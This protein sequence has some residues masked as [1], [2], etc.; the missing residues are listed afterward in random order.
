MQ[1]RIATG[2]RLGTSTKQAN[3]EAVATSVGF[4]TQVTGGVDRA[5]TRQGLAGMNTAAEKRIERKIQDKY[6]FINYFK[7]K[8]TDI[9]KEITSMRGEIE[10][11]NN[12]ITIYNNLNKT[13]ETLS[14]DVQNLEGELADYNLAGD[15]YRSSMRAEDI[16]G[17]FKHIRDN[18]KKKRDD[19]DYL[20]LEKAKREEE[21]AKIEFEHNKIMQAMEQRLNDLE[22]EQKIEYEQ[23]REENVHLVGKIHEVREEINRYNLEIAEGEN[24]LKNN[25]NKREAHKT[26]D[27]TNQYM[28]QI[29]KLERQTNESGKTVEELKA[30]LMAQA[31]EDLQEKSNL[32]KKVLEVKKI[33]DSYKKSISEIEKEMKSTSTNENV[34]AHDSI[35]QKDKEYSQLIDNFDE[36]KKAHLKD[37]SNKEEIVS[38]LLENISER[39]TTGTSSLSGE[40][41][42]YKEAA[43]D[44][45]TKE[46]L[47]K[48][49]L[50]TIEEAKHQY[51]SLQVKMK[52]LDNLE[53]TLKGEVKNF[54]EKLD[55]AHNDIIEKYDRIEYQKDYYRGEQKK[56]L[57]LL[58]Y[59]EKNKENYAKLLTSLVIKNRSKSTQL[60]D[61]DTYKKLREMEKKMQENENFIFSLTTFIESKANENDFTYLLKECLE[62]QQ[63][64]NNELIKRISIK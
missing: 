50:S 62:I 40:A 3:I 43:A 1:Q 45:R 23:F 58:K 53:E 8:N 64:I 57:E 34:K 52:R 30:E 9:A 5:V 2:V 48:H 6:Y 54:R 27:Q 31:K 11:I 32:D 4:N 29:Q 26:K 38:A 46:K 12:D 17:V 19:S 25:P 63:E 13:F 42:Q 16:E 41:A 37:L 56:M 14:K 59:L 7:K 60:E 47:I 49:G 55:R 22:P 24:L 44:K 33:I 61:S 39:L 35:S 20:Y 18:N 21:L 10:S 15:K 28:R 51:E 36:I